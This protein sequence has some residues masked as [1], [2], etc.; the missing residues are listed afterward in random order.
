MIRTELEEVLVWN[1][2]DMLYGVLGGGGISIK[3]SRMKTTKSCVY[4]HYTTINNNSIN[5]SSRT[6]SNSSSG[7]SGGGGRIQE[8]Q[9]AVVIQRKLDIVGPKF[10]H[11]LELGYTPELK[12]VLHKGDEEGDKRRLFGLLKQDDENDGGGGEEERRARM[13]Q[14]M[15][16]K[17]M[18]GI[19]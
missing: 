7:S 16:I 11:G 3:K 1:T 19:G 4:V 14:M 8:E 6:R 15:W 9:K 17:G 18:N 13:V 2:A 12:F 10:R 5:N